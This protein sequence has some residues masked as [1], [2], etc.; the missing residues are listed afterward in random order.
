M[1]IVPHF[2]LFLNI[3]RFAAPLSSS[4]QLRVIY[5]VIMTAVQEETVQS[6]ELVWIMYN[7]MKGHNQDQDPVQSISKS[8]LMEA[9]TRHLRA[10]P[11]RC[12]DVHSCS[13]DPGF[14]LTQVRIETK[15]HGRSEREAY[16]THQVES[17]QACAAKL[18]SFGIP[19]RALPISNSVDVVSLGSHNEWLQ[20]QAHKEMNET[21]ETSPFYQQL[22]KDR[23]MDLLEPTPIRS[24]SEIST[25]HPA[26]RPAIDPW[27]EASRAATS[28][29]GTTFN[30]KHI[31]ATAQVLISQQGKLG[32][33][34]K[35]S[36]AVRGPAMSV[37]S[38]ASP[39][40]FTSRGAVDYQSSSLTTI[41]EG[42][43]QRSSHSRYNILGD[44]KL[45]AFPFKN[46][47]DANIG[48]AS[49]Q[50]VHSPL[51]APSVTMSDLSGDSCTPRPF[52]VLFGR[53]KV[54]DHPGNIQLHKL[55][56]MH[57]AKYDSAERWEKTVIA[58][59]IVSSIR[60]F[61]G[62]FLK[63]V[64]IHN[65][66]HQPKKR[67]VEVD[68]DTAREKVSHTFR[69]KR[70][71]NVKVAHGSVANKDAPGGLLR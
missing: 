40:S 26:V 27:D 51:L 16:H 44:H 41:H 61:D 9:I 11:I 39:P 42:S 8:M 49:H 64:S 10:L 60:Q 45:S 65:H 43:S 7:M 62:R 66:Q 47:D 29:R 67:W 25:D 28:I 37:V 20:R 15:V 35:S 57:Q 12:A 55:I 33:S 38:L 32:Q 53:G 4:C 34:C 69:S 18:E 19:A 6:Q 14:L 36:S 48:T 2:R 52:D 71:K 50:S 54:K 22:Q 46:S 17:P 63:L 3:Y 30:H 56:A 21:L 1:L 24:S 58:E 70:T 13:N 68:P 23:M 59:D 31:T 5:Y